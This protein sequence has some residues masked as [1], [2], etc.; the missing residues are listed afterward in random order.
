MKSLKVLH[1]VNTYLPNTENWLFGLLS[2]SKET[3]HQI[4][5]F[6]FTTNLLLSPNITL[7]LKLSDPLFDMKYSS[8]KKGLFRIFEKLKIK[9]LEYNNG[10]FSH[11]ISRY[12]ENNSIDILHAHFADI[13]WQA[14]QIKRNSQLPFLISFYGWDYEKLPFVQPK[15]KERFKILFQK[16]D[17]FICEGSHGAKILS[18][19]ECPTEKIHIVPLGVNVNKI[20]YFARTKKPNTLKL[21]QL[22]S[23]TEKK[24][25]EYSIKAFKKALNRCPNMTLTF[26]GNE[27]TTGLLNKLKSM[28]KEYEIQNN[29][30][31]LPPIDYKNLH[32]S[33]KKYDV[34]IHPS[35]YAANKDCEGGAPVVLLDA[36]ATGMPV[37]STTHCDIPDEVIQN[38]T[39]KLSTEKDIKAL[40][41]SIE[42]FYEMEENEYK[43]YSERARLH[44]ENKYDIIRNATVLEKVYRKYIHKDNLN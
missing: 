3:N 37:I 28:V 22:A 25:H 41:E 4:A 30:F 5:A 26:I 8:N 15:F 24:G 33:L 32:D 39:G 2:N 19:L 7:L 10:N 9:Y 6:R 13:G 14:L 42:Y 31:F 36:Q 38:K 21:I 1:L 23:Y 35:C 16:A 27:R 29:V 43:A 20:T 11:H 18:K 34:F 40:S 17:G 12:L 44:I